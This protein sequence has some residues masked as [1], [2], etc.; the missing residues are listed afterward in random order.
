M[1]SIQ[2]TSRL[3]WFKFKRKLRHW[4]QLGDWDL[5]GPTPMRLSKWEA[6]CCTILGWR[7]NDDLRE[8]KSSIQRSAGRGAHT[9][10]NGPETPPIRQSILK[11]IRGVSPHLLIHTNCREQ[12]ISW[13]HARMSVIKPLCGV[14]GVVTQN[15]SE[16]DWHQTWP[17]QPNESDRT[18]N[19]IIDRPIW[20]RMSSSAF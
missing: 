20:A 12:A 14:T 7:P 2:I 1:S 13:R 3:L 6:Y 10:R 8:F 9:R 19:C 5:K 4:K 18:V 16:N 15:E 17:M 11:S